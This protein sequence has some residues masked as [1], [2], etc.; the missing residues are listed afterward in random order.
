MS[1]STEDCVILR[2]SNGDYRDVTLILVL[3]DI[4]ASENKYVVYLK[5]IPGTSDTTNCVMLYQVLVI[6]WPVN[7]GVK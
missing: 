4:C 3:K 2:L 5:Y 6:R 1:V 7:A